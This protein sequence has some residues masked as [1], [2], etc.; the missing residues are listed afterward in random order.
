MNNIVFS[1]IFT[2]TLSS[3]SPSPESFVDIDPIAK[4][5]IEF[6]I[7]SAQMVMSIARD[8]DAGKTLNENTWDEL[9]SSPGYKNYL[10][11][12]DST[13]KKDLIKEAM[14]TVFDASNSSK[15][16]SLMSLTV[17]LDDN[18]FKLSLVHN[19]YRLKCNLNQ[20]DSYLKDT[21]FSKVLTLADSL[22]QAYLPPQVRNSP[23]NLY[24]VFVV[25]SDPDGRVQKN[26]ILLD[27]NLIFGLGKDGLIKFIAHEFHHNYRALV[28]NKYNSPL[29]KELN[30]LHQEAIADLIDKEKPP[31]EKLGLFPSSVVDEYNT[32]YLNTP[33]NLRILDSLV[34]G[35]LTNKIEETEFQDKIKGFF[36]FGGHT[37]GI[38]MSFMI[39]E[40]IGKE[41][42]IES[43]DN[44]AKF[45]SIYNSVAKEQKNEYA[46]SDH[47]MEYVSELE[48]LATA[49]C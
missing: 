23:P 1:L 34:V 27:L 30:K 49:N 42:L 5:D 24:P 37:S 20:L 18:F 6:N 47:F 16:D 31:L 26:S 13:W 38:Y 15:L 8:I 3:C 12:R 48:E 22:A 44:S 11:Y 17:T 33:D 21:D 39:N 19:F 41:Q 2:L 35:Y 28:E 9:F 46:F 14:L 40:A 43:Y 25:V 10:V 7:S 29:M 36:K 4:A 45:L 32:D